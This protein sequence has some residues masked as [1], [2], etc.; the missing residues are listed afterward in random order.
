MN[1]WRGNY[2]GI[3]PK[4]KLII[5][6]RSGG[7]DFIGLYMSTRGGIITPDTRTNL[8]TKKLLESI[9]R[10]RKYV[11]RLNYHHFSQFDKTLETISPKEYQ[12]TVNKTTL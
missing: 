1:T 2:Y 10:A 11:M 3:I 6:Y 5:L 12:N 7:Y 9:K 4:V 8:K